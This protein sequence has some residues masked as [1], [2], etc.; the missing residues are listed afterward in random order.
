[1]VRHRRQE[2]SEPRYIR[3]DAIKYVVPSPEVQLMGSGNGFML[4]I[5]FLYL[6][7]GVGYVIDRK[8]WLAVVV[9]C[10]AIANVAMVLSVMAAAK[11]L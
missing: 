8:G 5:A 7:A 11:K 1:M 9:V 4:L 3:F 6:C 2:R 10:Y